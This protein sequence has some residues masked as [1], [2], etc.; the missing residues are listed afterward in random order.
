MYPEDYFY[1][2][3]GLDCSDHAPL[4]G[5][6]YPDFVSRFLETHASAIDSIEWTA[7]AEIKSE[8][9]N[10]QYALIEP[11]DSSRVPSEELSTRW[12]RAEENATSTE[13]TITVRNTKR[14]YRESQAIQQYV[15][16]R[17]NG[18][19]EACSEDAPF[20][21]TR[22]H[23]YLEFH[24]VDKFEMTE[25]DLPARVVARCPTCHTRIH[26]AADGVRLNE[27]LRMKLDDG[28]G[29]LDS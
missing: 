28:L 5:T 29:T 9:M 27:E 12:N 16:C 13:D 7:L 18:V 25:P 19:C 10:A 24:H 26:A 17:A 11:F 15:R 21:D 14:D 1:D 3:D 22:G 6:F 4:I 8:S 2:V 20:E 23:P